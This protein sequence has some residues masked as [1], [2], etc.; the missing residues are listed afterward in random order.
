MGLVFDSESFARGFLSVFFGNCL[1]IRYSTLRD[2][3]IRE[4]YDNF[5]FSFQSDKLSRQTKCSNEYYDTGLLILSK[6]SIHNA[7]CIIYNETIDV[8]SKGLLKCT[9]KDITMINTHTI[10]S[11][12]GRN[13]MNY[14]RRSQI[15]AIR[16]HVKMEEKLLIGGDLNID[17]NISSLDITDALAIGLCHINQNKYL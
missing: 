6:H 14:V 13:L 8:G 17:K 11:S 7:E 12:Y 5:P 2:E 1:N 9:I 10:P 3:I 16:Q 4:S 15:N